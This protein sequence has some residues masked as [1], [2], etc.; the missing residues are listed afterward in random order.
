MTNTKP[1]NKILSERP[2]GYLLAVVAGAFGGPI[3]LVLSPGVLFI[4]NK[5]MKPSKGKQPNRFAAW[6][7][8]GIIGVPLSLAGLGLIL[9]DFLKAPQT[10]RG[11]D[12][13]INSDSFTVS[14]VRIEPFTGNTNG[15]DV[16]GAL[17]VVYADISNKSKVS[18]SP[19]SDL[20]TEVR[21]SS[22]RVFKEA[23]FTVI[24][25]QILD[26]SSGAQKVTKFSDGILP[27]ST[28]TNVQVGIF[29]VSNGAT[30][31]K[32]C[33]GSLFSEKQCIKK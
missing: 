11:G 27:G 32:L 6:A 5:V 15:A 10:L 16:A 30:G 18:E 22:G 31:L 17:W 21:D 28:R 1:T 23:D 13:T 2:E 20:A 25:N 3:G 29:D 24:S 19:S 14:N 7:L 4:L 26:E 8:F 33:A 9:P 12:S